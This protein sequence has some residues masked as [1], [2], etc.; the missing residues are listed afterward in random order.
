MSKKELAGEIISAV[1]YI[2]LGFVIT[3]NPGTSA[4]LICRIMGISALAYGAFCI[5]FYFI[6]RG[7]D[8]VSRFILPMG[9]AF[10]ALGAFCLVAPRV[11]LSVIPLLFGVVLLIDGAGKMGRAFEL[12]R[13]GFARWSMLAA[14]AGLIMFLGAM[15]MLQPYMA[16]ETVMRLFG[17]LLAADGFI[18][19]YF[20]V[21]IYSLRNY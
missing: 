13:L 1:I 9:I 12:R 20:A 15:L 2:A 5:I 19:I 6:R 11:L 7:E 10:A 4:D 21:R 18:E 8:D 17:A 14:V 16:V 3:L